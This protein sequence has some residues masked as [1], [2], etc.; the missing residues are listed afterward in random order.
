MPL[1]IIERQGKRGRGW[2]GDGIKRKVAIRSFG[3]AA[4][5]L[6]VTV[7]WSGDRAKF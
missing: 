6:N 7:S 2:L 5:F 1:Y 4:E 3:V